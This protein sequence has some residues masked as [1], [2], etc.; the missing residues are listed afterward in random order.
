[1]SIS[2]KSHI[3][4]SSDLEK[5]RFPKNPIWN[6]IEIHFR[7]KIDFRQNLKM[8]KFQ[9][10]ATKY[11]LEKKVGRKWPRWSFHTSSK[12][13]K[14]LITAS[15]CVCCEISRGGPAWRASVTHTH[16]WTSHSSNS[17][18]TSRLISLRRTLR[19]RK[20][21][22][23]VRNELRLR[24]WIVAYVWNLKILV[25][26]LILSYMRWDCGYGQ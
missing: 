3:W 25:F 4:F 18:Y 19:G 21:P 16:T 11:L 17:Q 12:V 22:Q 26:S 8:S 20:R 5:S 23:R 2:Q 15:R 14:Y 13:P 24:L 9:N 7:W 1:M 10:F 6:P